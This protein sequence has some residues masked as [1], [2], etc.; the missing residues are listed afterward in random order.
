MQKQ[1]TNK[2][3]TQRQESAI[4]LLRSWREG[5]EQE[6]RETW[7]FLKRALDEEVARY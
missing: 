5:D 1:L 3:N 6:Q 7:E 2:V 4:Q